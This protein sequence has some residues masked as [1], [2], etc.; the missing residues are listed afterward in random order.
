[1]PIVLNISKGQLQK[2]AKKL[3]EDSSN[4]RA[5]DASCVGMINALM[6]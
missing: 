3:D 6:R 1:M 4:I 5:A 2:G